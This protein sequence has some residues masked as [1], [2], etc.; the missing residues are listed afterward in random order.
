MSFNFNRT[1]RLNLV[2]A[3]TGSPWHWVEWSRI[4]ADL[5]P[6]VKACRGTPLLKSLQR[7]AST[8]E[9]LK[10]GK[11]VWN[12]ESFQKWT[13]GSPLTTTSSATWDFFNTEIAAPSLPTCAK[14]GLPPDFFLVI[15]NEKFNHT[16]KQLAFTMRLIVA[17]A[18]DMDANIHSTLQSALENFATR[19]T[20]LLTA[21]IE[22]PWGKQQGSSYTDSVQDIPH[23]GLFK[24]GD[25]HSRPVNLETLADNWTTQRPT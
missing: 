23:V 15:H 13:H 6:V 18:T 24:L 25:Y 2:L 1:Y 4:A 8:K 7:Q 5:D 12:T 11:L 14:D 9:W 16:D 21:S 22:R 20:A 19:Y 17:L 10:F 3:P